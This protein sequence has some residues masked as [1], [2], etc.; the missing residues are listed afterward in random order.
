MKIKNFGMVKKINIDIA[1]LTIFVGQNSSGK[2]SIAKLIHCFNLNSKTNNITYKLILNEFI[3]ESNKKIF[4]KTLNEFKQYLKTKPT[5]NSDSF[6]ISLDEFKQVFIEGIER[7]FSQTF[8]NIL[9]K[10]FDENLDDLINLD[11]HYFKITLNNKFKIIKNK[12]ESLSFNTD[13]LNITIEDIIKIESNEETVNININSLV[14]TNE[15]NLFT[16]IY[17]LLIDSI[18]NEI[19]LYNS[20]Y[21][22]AERTE[23]INDK[24]LLNQKIKGQIELSKN[25]EDILANIYN[26]DVYKK[27]I[28]YDLACQ[29]E[30]ELHD[31]DTIIKYNG[32]FNEIHYLKSNKEISPKILSTSTTEMSIIILYLKYLLKKE[33]LLIIEEPE[34]HIHPKNQRILIKYLVKAVN[35]GLK[36]LF[37]THSDYIIDQINNYIGLNKIKESTLKEMGY[38]NDTKLTPSQLNI[39]HFKICSKNSV[40]VE[41]VKIENDGF[42]DENFSQIND[43]LY[44]ETLKIINY[45][46]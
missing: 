35:M 6:K 5:L 3:N 40:H 7:Y 21:I 34:A 36:V 20:H 16:M 30:K 27:S 19:L 11:E 39:Y 46:K 22:P 33:D 26:I 37:T 1:P 25:Q 24:K 2:S 45:T 31:I 23:F 12:S 28:F 18:F 13:T 42:I 15:K 14:F 32:I 43:E 44:D 4:Q 10:Q 38:D 41:K 17:R 29:A 9:I 8:E